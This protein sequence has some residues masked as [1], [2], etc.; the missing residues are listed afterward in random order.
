MASSWSLA[1]KSPEST[2]SRSACHSWRALSSRCSASALRPLSELERRC[3]PARA[4]RAS[5]RPARLRARPPA[6]A[7]RAPPG[8][9]RGLQAGGRRGAPGLRPACQH[10]PGR[11]AAARRTAAGPG[12]R[13]P[14]RWAHSAG[15]ARGRRRS[16]RR[17]LQGLRPGG[18]RAHWSRRAGTTCGAA[19]RPRR[20]AARR[21]AAGAAP[22]CCGCPR[23]CH[24]A[25]AATNQPGGSGPGEATA[26]HFFPDRVQHGAARDPIAP[27]GRCAPE[28]GV[29]RGARE[30]SR[31]QHAAGRRARRRRRRP[32]GR[33]R[34][35]QRRQ[36]CERG[37]VDAQHLQR[38]VQ[39]LR[40][41]GGQGRVRGH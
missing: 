11:W 5:A 28:S 19:A 4:P 1:A 12:W 21:R 17:Q 18:P 34:L 14:R 23:S 13:A 39:L 31:R 9:A 10:P 38:G 3:A 27:R 6:A 16:A 29:R 2:R 35:A 41:P 24:C 15:G 8:G 25:A 22:R 32:A 30:R 20:A 33:G 37:P 26:L 40:A 36:R 7:S